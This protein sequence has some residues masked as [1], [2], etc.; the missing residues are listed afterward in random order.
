LTLRAHAG[1]LLPSLP[2]TQKQTERVMPMLNCMCV[3]HFLSKKIPKKHHILTTE[4]PLP[5]WFSDLKLRLQVSNI[6]R[7]KEINKERNN[8]FVNVR[9][10]PS[11]YTN[12]LAV[13]RAS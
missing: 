4:A 13:V 6:L 1:M 2:N 5:C 12:I 8:F 7:E 11:G 10:F 3:L 9:R